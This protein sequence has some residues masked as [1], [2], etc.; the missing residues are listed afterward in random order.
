M[1]ES[2]DSITSCNFHFAPLF[3]IQ[4]A[5][6][7]LILQKMTKGKGKNPGSGGMMKHIIRR[8]RK[9]RLQPEERRH[10]GH[11]EKHRDYVSRAKI[12]HMKEDKVKKL[13]RQVAERNPDEFFFEM[14]HSSVDVR[15]GKH[16]T[17]SD[18]KRS[19]SEQVALNKDDIL[20]LEY[21]R[22]MLRSEMQKLREKQLRFIPT[23]G[24]R[25]GEDG[26]GE[27][28]SQQQPHSER[29]TIKKKVERAKK[30]AE[31]VCRHTTFVYASDEEFYTP[32]R[33]PTV[34]ETKTIPEV[35]KTEEDT[36]NKKALH[37]LE[38]LYKRIEQVLRVLQLQTN[39]IK[40]GKRKRIRT[41]E[42]ETPVY[43]WQTARRRN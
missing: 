3:E 19:S 43:R 23:V 35:P 14:I 22:N 11:L 1:I 20:Y 6:F 24:T 12:H 21:R 28:T 16:M 17:S 38:K 13:E 26:V 42:G 8:P 4:F 10:L 27:E 33:L 30:H 2:C 41:R 7:S 34:V 37:N 18:T 36:Q 9:E 39:L 15:T 40:K 25:A 31:G 5:S 32:N 29:T